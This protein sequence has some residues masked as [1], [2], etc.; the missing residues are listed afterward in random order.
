MLF[1]WPCDCLMSKWPRLRLAKYVDDL[2]IS[3]RGTNHMVVTV[4][5]GG[6]LENG[7]DFH[8]SKGHGGQVSGPGFEWCAQDGTGLVDEGTRH[9]GC[10]TRTYPGH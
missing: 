10:V 2:T 4:I 6:W 5:T 9:E 7:L 1:I 3:Y 8:V